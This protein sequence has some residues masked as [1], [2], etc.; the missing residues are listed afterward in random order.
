MFKFKIVF[1]KK[2]NFF[3]NLYVFILSMYILYLNGKNKLYNI[4]FYI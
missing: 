4:F 2:Y 1:K 3:F